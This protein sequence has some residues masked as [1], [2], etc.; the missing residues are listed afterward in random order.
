[1]ANYYYNINEI[2]VVLLE[3]LEDL[4]VGILD[5]T[6]AEEDDESLVRLVTPL[7]VAINIGTTSSGDAQSPGSEPEQSDPIYQWTHH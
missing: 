1:M 6:Y 5:G 2:N 7:L 4:V 3:I